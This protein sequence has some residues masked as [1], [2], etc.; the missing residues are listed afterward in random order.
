MSTSKSTRKPTKRLLQTHIPEQP[1]HGN[2]IILGNHIWAH[3]ESLTQTMKTWGET[4]GSPWSDVEVVLDVTDD[5]QI[6]HM[7]GSVSA[8]KFDVIL[9]M[10]SWNRNSP[11]VFPEGWNK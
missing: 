7:D 5:F 1:K 3:G 2:Y 8:S 10:P 4:G 9:Q 6:S 11:P